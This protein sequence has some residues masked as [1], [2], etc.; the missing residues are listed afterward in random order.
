ML[1]LS[2]AFSQNTANAEFGHSAGSTTNIV[3]RSGTNEFH[4]AVWEFLRNDAFDSS[5]AVSRTVE[6]LKRN[7]FGGVFGG[8]VKKEKTFF[9]GYYEDIRNR[10]GE[11]TL[12]AVPTAL[13]RNGDFSQSGG[14]LINE[15]AGVEFP[16]DKLPFITPTSRLLAI[17]LRGFDCRYRQFKLQR[18]ASQ[19]EGALQPA[20]FFS[21]LLHAFENAR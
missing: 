14:P 12:T 10:R 9:F 6:P 21:R 1:Y 17:S 11:S 15:F 16:G 3:T 18:A 4:G 7:Q 20:I 8:P 5:N 19:F 13:E 2:F